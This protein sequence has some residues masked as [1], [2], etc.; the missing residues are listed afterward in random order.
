MKQSDVLVLGA[1][2]GGLTAAS[3]LAKAGRKV[4]LLEAQDRAGGCGQ[5]F[6]RNG[7]SFCA[8]MQYLMGCAP[9]GIVQ[10]WLHALDLEKDIQFNALD[11]DGYDRIELPGLSFRI[12][13]DAQRLQ[14]AL[15]D[16]FPAE[17]ENIDELFAVLLRMEAEIAGG[18]FEA[19]RFLRHP[20]QFK[21][22]VL[23]GP[24]PVER[25]FDHFDLS[26]KLR[27]V[28]SGQCG[29]VGLAPREEPFLCLQSVLFGY[30]E[31]AHFPKRGMGHFVDRVVDFILRHGGEIHFATP[32][33]A[34]VRDGDRIARVTTPRGPFS[35]Q[36]VVSN[37]DPATTLAMIEGA[38]VPSYE[39]S[40]SCFTIFLGLDIDLGKHGFG[41]S[42]VWHYP[43]EDLDAVLARTM[44]EHNYEDP[45]FFLSTPSLYADPGI[46]APPGCTTVQ[47]N[48]GSDFDYF[49]AAQ[50]EGRHAVEKA[51]V[52][53]EILA[54]VERR[55][56]P[57]LTRHCV[58][59][60]SWSPVDL[61]LKVGLPRGGMYGARL[62][63][64][65]RVLRRVSQRTA[66]ENLFLTG[67]TAGSP[68]LQ[69]VVAAS[70]RLVQ[71]L[72]TAT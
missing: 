55:L 18:V 35:A 53:A 30:C 70:T 45:F 51:R 14:A 56:L 12:P 64:E 7:F 4:V 52:T 11:A 46:L 28:L 57:G 41:R 15:R 62:D 21:D 67:A 44:K 20:F 33:T 8:E 32:V 24:W 36:T 37:M 49:A 54:A 40:S 50:R 72:L 29:D 39:P 2:W 69:G 38:N 19:K 9:S 34:L 66:F 61:A 1:G 63:F 16:A 6:E 59:Q 31:S 23:Y 60:E 22:T 13:H 17:Q 68:G 71:S 10:Q 26:P 43:D 25:V 48:V 65:N 42:N 27:A 3:L 47:I 58:V 5:S